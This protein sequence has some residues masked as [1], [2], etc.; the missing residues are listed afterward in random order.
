[1]RILLAAA[2]VTLAL[3]GCYPGEVSSVE[4]LDVFITFPRNDANFANYQTF[5][6]PDTVVQIDEDSSE[7]QIDHDNDAEIVDQVRQNLLD[8]GFT[9]VDFPAESPD[10]FVLVSAVADEYTSISWY[11]GYWWGYWGWYYPCYYCYP[12]Y[13][14][15]YVTVTT[16]DAGTLFIDMLDPDVAFADSTE[17]PLVWTA[18]A[19]GLIVGTAGAN[20]T[21]LLN[22]VDRL[23]AQSPYLGDGK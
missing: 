3:A 9:E 22:G 8:L 6:I 17:V 1:M 12:G 13:P 19:N 5:S 4:E 14:P 2:A 23:F 7:I 18:A 21:R 10:V 11:P 20:L 15:G 16:Y